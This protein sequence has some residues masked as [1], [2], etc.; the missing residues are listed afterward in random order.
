[1]KYLRVN[2]QK[3]IE[4]HLG[5]DNAKVLYVGGGFKINVVER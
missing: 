2:G 4:H 5:E 1:M 3:V